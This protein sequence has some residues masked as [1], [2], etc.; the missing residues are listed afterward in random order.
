MIWHFWEACP[1]KAPLKSSRAR[2]MNYR[3]R[4]CLKI[5][6]NCHLLMQA[7]YPSMEHFF[8]PS[9]SLLHGCRNYW[10]T[11]LQQQHGWWELGYPQSYGLGQGADSCFFIIISSIT[12]V[13]L[14]W[15]A[16]TC[17]WNKTNCKHL[18]AVMEPLTSHHSGTSSPLWLTA[19]FWWP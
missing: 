2:T 18:T 3:L 5:R 15:S 19:F 16:L 13:I 6:V 14:F 10:G 7:F 11:G 8:L 17:M 12:A 4:N 1:D 9:L